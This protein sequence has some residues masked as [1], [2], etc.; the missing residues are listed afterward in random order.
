[1]ILWHVRYVV[2]PNYR[3]S[4]LGLSA[5]H[6]NPSFPLFSLR[7]AFFVDGAITTISCVF[8]LSATQYIVFKAYHRKGEFTIIKNRY[9]LS[10]RVILA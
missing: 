3:I 4:S 1:M 9:F 5:N 2:F 8:K 6:A 7:Q 10:P